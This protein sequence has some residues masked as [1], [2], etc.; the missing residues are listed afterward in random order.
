MV[1][2]TAAALGAEVVL[3]DLSVYIPAVLQN[4]QANQ[5]ISGKVSAEALDW[6][7]EVPPGLKGTADV[8]IVCDCIY[9]EASLQPLIDTILSLTKEDTS[10]ILAYEKRQDKLELYGEFFS[11]LCK[12]FSSREIL[13]VTAASSNEIYLL[14]LTLLE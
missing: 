6:K 10:I 8:V 2:L 12:H 1:G 7:G 11:V 3:T 9:Y 4:I 14:E 13:R 5:D